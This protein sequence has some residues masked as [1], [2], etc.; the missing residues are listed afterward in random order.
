MTCKLCGLNEEQQLLGSVVKKPTFG[1]RYAVVSDGVTLQDYSVQKHN[2]STQGKI[3]CQLLNDAGINPDEVFFTNVCC[4][5]SINNRTPS[6]NEINICKQRMLNELETFKPDVVLVVGINSLRAFLGNDVKKIESYRGIPIPFNNYYL[7]PTYDIGIAYKVNPDYF[8]DIDRDVRKLKLSFPL[9]SIDDIMY[10]VVEKVTDI[11]HTTDAIAVDIESTSLSTVDKGY[12]TCI[13]IAYSNNEAII[14]PGELLQNPDINACLTDIF[15]HAYIITHN[16]IA[17]DDSYTQLKGL[18]PLET[19]FDTMIGHYIVDPRVPMNVHSL[20]NVAREYLGIA[21]WKNEVKNYIKG[22]G[23]TYANIPRDLLYRYNARD[24]C[25]TFAI[26]DLIK[27]EIVSENKSKLLFELVQPAA[28]VLAK[29]KRTGILI[30]RFR[31]MKLGLDF[32][33]RADK[34]DNELRVITDNPKFNSNSW[35]QVCAYLY[36]ECKLPL[37][38]YGRSSDKKALKILKE[39]FPENEAL[40][41]ITGARQLKHFRSTYVEGIMALCDDDSILRGNIHVYSTRSGRLSSFL[42]TIPKHVGK[43]IRYSFLPPPGRK[44]IE[45]DYSQ[46]EMRYAAYITN[47]KV[48]IDAFLSGAD[49]HKQTAA[50][51]FHKKVEDVTDEERFA[52]KTINFGVMYGMQEEKLARTLKC[53]TAEAKL[54]LLEYAKTYHGLHDWI[55]SVQEFI[56][57]NNY[58]RMPNGRTRHFPLITSK[59]RFEVYREAVNTMI[60]GPASDICLASLIRLDKTLLSDTDLHLTIHDSILAS[61]IQYNEAAIWLKKEMENVPIDSPVP[62]T[63]DIV[64]GDNW[65]TMQENKEEDEED[66]GTD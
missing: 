35:K 3:I 49:F 34:M 63:V 43:E 55:I 9:P 28:R 62:F 8:M 19:D 17:F 65:G 46:L 42:H 6:L 20:D 50:F 13:G 4:C 24:V 21:N 7:I 40:E 53:S 51:M 48:L 30:D 15:E 22:D 18:L 2:T 47:D 38:F 64:V 59:N 33:D 52:A 25:A 41:R 23:A 1:K 56:E 29:M 11:I 58:V 60:Q 54:Y 31:L 27:S 16:G 66:E 44:L 26:H 61:S 36:D 37:T 39:K 12:I 32:G 5:T 10:T 45:G 57:K 14:T